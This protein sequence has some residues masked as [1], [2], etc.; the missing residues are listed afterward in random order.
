M[1]LELGLRG[2]EG[3]SS[4]QTTDHW[5]VSSSKLS[6]HKDQ[7]KTLNDSATNHIKPLQTRR[8]GHEGAH[9][10]DGPKF[11]K[12]LEWQY[13]QEG[14]CDTGREK[15]MESCMETCSWGG[16]SHFSDKKVI[17]DDNLGNTN[18]V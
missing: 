7:E 4:L 1:D 14:I 8:R 13:P 17:K 3:R 6:H 5:L 12:A 9:D 18:F 16:V 10:L 11:Q 15:G 2:F